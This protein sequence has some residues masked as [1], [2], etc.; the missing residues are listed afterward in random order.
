MLTI[1]LMISVVLTSCGGKTKKGTMQ[2]AKPVPFTQLRERRIEITHTFKHEGFV[3][4]SDF[5]REEVYIQAISAAKGKYSLVIADIPTGEV[6]K[7]MQL[8]K[9]GFGS[10]I[11]FYSPSYMQYVKGNYL[12]VDQFHKIMVYD[13]DLNYRYTNMFHMLRFFIDFFPMEDKISFVIGKNLCGIKD[14]AN[15]IY[16]YSMEENR[17]PEHE[18]DL[19]A[20][21][22]PAL[23]IKSRQSEKYEYTAGIWPSG[24]G[25]EK[26]GMVYYANYDEQQYYVHNIAEAKTVVFALHYLKPKTFSTEESTKIEFYHSTGVS[27]RAIRRIGKRYKV[28]L[29]P[30]P[31]YQFGIF[32]VGEKKIGIIGDL[33]ADGFQFRLDILDA[34]SGAYLESIRL[35]FG[36]SLAYNISDSANG[37]V[38]T[39]INVDKGYYL[40]G[41]SEGE[42]LIDYARITWFK[43]VRE[44]GSQPSGQEE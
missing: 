27:E 11:E 10:P 23:E 41:K 24:N 26:D 25:F 5:Q 31:M 33:D 44:D 30:K 29:Y 16:L 13:E 22:F 38:P 28:D 9:G 35:P 1:V 34:V 19:H 8:R 40:W 39:Y 37:Q 6:K 3:I 43:I 21:I 36:D 2:E 20:F 32:D 17:K 4:G 18:K 14:T 15:V 42:E 12:I 7:E